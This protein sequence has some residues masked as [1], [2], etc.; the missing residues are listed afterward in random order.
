MNGNVLCR[1]HSTHLIANL[2]LFECN[3]SRL[4]KAGTLDVLNNLV[5]V[6]DMESK[7]RVSF[8]FHNLYKH[9]E[10]HS[11][12]EK[13]EVTRSLASLLTNVDEFTKLHSCLAL[14]YLSISVKARAQFVEYGGLPNLLEIAAHED[15]ELKREALAALRNI[16]ISDHNKLS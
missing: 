3:H 11:D 1:R 9:I 5:N 12:C 10:S 2:G 13:A 4:I 14:K 16:S 7:R 8:A 15:K 6:E